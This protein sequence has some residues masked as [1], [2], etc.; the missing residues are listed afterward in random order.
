MSTPS[1]WW[2]VSLTQ[3]LV[4][5]RVM[6]YDPDWNPSTDMQ[7]RERAWRIG[8]KRQ[9]QCLAPRLALVAEGIVLA[10]STAVHSRVVPWNGNMA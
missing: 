1:Q 6:V 7:A 8:Q 10:D 2:A 3:L 5:C 9:V 4:P